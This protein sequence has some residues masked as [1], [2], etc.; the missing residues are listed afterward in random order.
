MIDEDVTRIIKTGWLKWKSV[1][2]VSCNRM[3]TTK[4]KVCSTVIRPTMLYGSEC[5]GH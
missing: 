1:N 3:I 4:V 2:W 5:L